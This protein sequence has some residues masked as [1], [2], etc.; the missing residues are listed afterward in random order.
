MKPIKVCEAN[1]VHEGQVR[2]AKVNGQSV[3]MTRVRGIAG[4]F[5]GKCPHLNL[6]LT[7]GKVVDGTIQ[8]PWHGSRFDILTG[9]N[10]DWFSR[11]AGIS[12]PKWSRALI[13][14]GK[15]PVPLPTFKV[16]EDGGS[17]FVTLP[18]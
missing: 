14:L 7:R 5:L 3:L 2:A 8:C 11:F 18:S 15:Q 17:V 4:A 10:L 12:M 1:E 16:L 13:A 9:K 6:P